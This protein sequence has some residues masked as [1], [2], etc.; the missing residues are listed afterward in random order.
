MP[1]GPYRM[2]L[3]TSLCLIILITVYFN[4]PYIRPDQTASPLESFR[5]EAEIPSCIQAS[6][7]SET[8]LF[9]GATLHN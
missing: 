9:R 2:F 6:Q 3:R 1:V 4:H 8:L 7:C 5:H